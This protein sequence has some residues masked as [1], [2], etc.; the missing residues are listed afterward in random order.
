VAVKEREWHPIE[1]A[2]KDGRWILLFCARE[3][4]DGLQVFMARWVGEWEGPYADGYGCG[5]E[6]IGARELTHWM[7]MPEPPQAEG[8]DA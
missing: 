4:H 6:D 2:P 8:A 5:L 1:T 7:P 3:A